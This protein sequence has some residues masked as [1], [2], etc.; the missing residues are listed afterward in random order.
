MLMNHKNFY[1]TQIPDETNDAIFLKSP[2]TMF[3][4]IFDIFGHFWLMG[5]F[6]KKSSFVTHNF[7]WA[8]NTTLSLKKKTIPRKLM[9]RRKDGRTGPIL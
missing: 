4:A 3:W 6:S 9:D 7:I 1:F 2:K 5:I 8:P